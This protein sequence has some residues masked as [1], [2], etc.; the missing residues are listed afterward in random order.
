MKLKYFLLLTVLFFKIHGN[1]FSNDLI[2]ELN[3]TGRH[4]EFIKLLQGSPL[5]PSI[6]N[7][8]VKA[9]MYAPTNKAFYNADMQIKENINKQNSKVTTKIILSHI[10]SGDNLT[11]EKNS[12][13][14]VLTLDGSIYF[15]YEVGDLF[16]KDIVIQG[17]PFFSNNYTIIPVDCLMYIQP[18]SKDIRIDKKIQEEYRYTSCC[19]ENNQEV[20]DFLGSL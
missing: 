14:M 5:L 17:E 11:T 9:T 2:N 13:G 15:T 16:V 7:N 19:L 18:S 8:K 12:E 3:R 4:T 6:L 20:K 1:S 10:F